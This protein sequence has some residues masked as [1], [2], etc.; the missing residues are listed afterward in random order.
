MRARRC[1]RT[2]PLVSICQGLPG[3]Q[4]LPGLVG[5]QELDEVMTSMEDERRNTFLGAM[6]KQRE[7]LTTKHTGDRERSHREIQEGHAT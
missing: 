6:A 2:A 3:P 1:T 4:R 5:L 7:Q